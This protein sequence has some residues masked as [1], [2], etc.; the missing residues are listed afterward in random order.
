MPSYAR[1]NPLTHSLPFTDG[2][3]ACWLVYVEPAPPE[4]SLWPT[5]AVLPGRRVRFDSL[6]GSMVATPVPAGAPFLSQGRLQ[7]LLDSAE[8]IEVTARP[9]Q[10]AIPAPPIRSTGWFASAAALVLLLIRDTIL[11]RA[12]G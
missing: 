5:S 6:E 7:E 10:E 2:D 12:R 3:G 8:P 4:P 11:P 9:G 1:G